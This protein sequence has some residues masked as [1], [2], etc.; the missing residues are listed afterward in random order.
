MSAIEDQAK[1]PFLKE[2]SSFVERFGLGL[3][4]LADYPGVVRRAMEWARDG[5]DGKV[6]M[7]NPKD[8]ETDILA[9]PLALAFVY[10][11]KK[12]WAVNRFATSE[13][14]R[15]DGL[16]RLEPKEKLVE[17]AKQ[18]FGWVME[19]LDLSMEEKQFDFRIGTKE[20]LDVAP[21]F[22]SAEWKLVNRFVR[23]GKV[24]IK[25][26]EAARLLSGAVKN[27]IIGR[28]S[29]EEIRKF[30][31]PGV[32]SPQMDSLKA[33]A[34][35]KGQV[36]EDSQVLVDLVEA[37]PPCVV[38]IINDLS[39]GKNLS[40]MAR[41]TITTFMINVGKTVDDVLLM[42]SNVADFD[43]GKARYQVEHIAGEIGSKT[44]YSTPKCDVLR[45]FGLCVNPNRLCEEIWHPLI[46]YRAR[47]EELQKGTKTDGGKENA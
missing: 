3:K 10:G 30:E 21:H 41:F 8:P 46:Y 12:D 11:L 40:H 16:M 13:Q 19:P 27:K 45:S 29:E 9:Y 20:Y 25:K 39:A 17:I 7:I 28:A 36:Y 42:F 1:Y 47:V 43:V 14:K 44:K 6:F 31:V 32:F 15:Y 34:A 24:Y 26:T 22:H 5:L 33:I 23:G 35:K 2:A 37:R 38:A 18:G 4:E